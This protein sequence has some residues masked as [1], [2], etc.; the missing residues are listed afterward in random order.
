EERVGA[1]QNNRHH[2]PQ[3]PTATTPSA[4]RSSHSASSILRPCSPTRWVTKGHKKRTRSGTLGYPIGSSPHR[5]TRPCL[6]SWPG[7]GNGT[8]RGCPSGSDDAPRPAT[9]LSGDDGACRS[10]A[11]RNHAGDD[12]T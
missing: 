2:G 12:F 7:W 9:D 6:S 10:C 11:A 1:D 8:R 4:Y 3:A 5:G